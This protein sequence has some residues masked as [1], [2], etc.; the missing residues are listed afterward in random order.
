MREKDAPG[1]GEVRVD[2]EL[3]L[4]GGDLNVELEEIGVRAELRRSLSNQI[5]GS[6]VHPNSAE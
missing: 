6:V 1:A 4:V 3:S 2:V 5:S